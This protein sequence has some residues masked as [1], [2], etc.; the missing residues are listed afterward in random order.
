GNLAPHLRA[1][2]MGKPATTVKVATSAAY[3]H[4]IK[5]TAQCTAHSMAS[6]AP[7]DLSAVLSDATSLQELVSDLMMPFGKDHVDQV[8]AVT[9]DGLRLGQASTDVPVENQYH[10]ATRAIAGAVAGA[11]KI[12]ERPY[13]GIDTLMDGQPLTNV[14]AY[15]RTAKSPSF[16]L[17]RHHH[18]LR[19]RSVEENQQRRCRVSA[20]L[21]S[22]AGVDVLSK[23]DAMPSAPGPRFC[24]P[25][26]QL[27]LISTDYYLVRAVLDWV[28]EV[29][30][31]LAVR[32]AIKSLGAEVVGASFVVATNAMLLSALKKEQ[33]PFSCSWTPSHGAELTTTQPKRSDGRAQCRCDQSVQSAGLNPS[34]PRKRKRSI[35]CVSANGSNA[36][37]PKLS[38]FT[39]HY[40]ANAPGEDRSVNIQKPG[41]SGI[42]IFAVF[43]GHGGHMAVEHLNAKLCSSILARVSSGLTTDEITAVLRDAFLECDN[44]LKDALNKLPEEIRMSRG[45]CNT[46]S[47]AAIAMFVDGTLYVAN[48]GDCG[49]YLGVDNGCGSLFPVQLSAL[50]NCDNAEETRLVTERSRD[51]NAIRFSKDDQVKVVENGVKRVAGSLA[52][53]RA[54][55]DFYLKCEELSTP[56]FKSKV[57]YITAEPSVTVRKLDGSEKFLILASD[58]LWEMVE[59]EDA[60]AVV[61]GFA[62]EHLFFSS[63][64]AAL[65]H[66][67]L[68]EVARREE[69]SLREL[70]AMTP[71]TERRSYHDDITCTVVNISY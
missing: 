42:Q 6:T 63:V 15:Q 3:V 10:A 46:G 8:A 27:V 16:R 22:A 11:N 36:F 38:H 39:A 21:W 2:T 33:I 31:I 71:G 41:E 12:G 4:R 40:H 9:I 52:V 48:V 43:D 51:R 60:L 19:L 56:P 23:C 68:D 7:I 32:D 69:V 49:V 50:H 66:A 70:L 59:P 24:S 17:R 55:G 54:F 20:L 58:G 65:V 57:P 53:T 26:S 34:G 62:P 45:Y 18:Q 5:L 47:C 37:L 1:G 64:S 13:Y 14:H 25:L 28:D 61:A 35:D 44:E 30:S 67:A 29:D